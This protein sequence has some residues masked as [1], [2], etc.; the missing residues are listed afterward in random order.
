MSS[1]LGLKGD[2]SQAFIIAVLLLLIGVALVA[3]FTDINFD[4]S[5]TDLFFAGIGFAAGIV[6][7]AIVLGQGSLNRAINKIRGMIGGK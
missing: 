4:F 6:L 5:A 3:T 7:L 2:N 1:L